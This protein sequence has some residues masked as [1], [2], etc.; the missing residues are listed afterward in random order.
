M[1]DH[2]YDYYYHPDYAAI[3]FAAVWV[4][5]AVALMVLAVV[6]GWRIFE[7]AGKK[8]WAA[9]IPFYR[10]Y[11]ECQIYWGEGWLF[12]VPIVLGLLTFIPFVGFMFGV[13]SVVFGVI[14]KYKKAEA[15][16]ERIGFTVGLVL[17]P[18]IFDLILAF[19]S[20]Y[21]YHGVP[22]DAVNYRDIKARYDAVNSRPVEYEAPPADQERPVEY[23]DSV[24]KNDSDSE[25]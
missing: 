17:L 16:G 5:I 2:Y 25:L 23:E 8:G 6:S 21:Y 18:F 14:T 4:I 7:K 13:G 1:Y 15:F 10:S 19:S 3:G 9:L 20:R 12:L 11:V 24:E 22:I